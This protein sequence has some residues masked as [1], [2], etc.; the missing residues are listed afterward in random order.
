[1]HSLPPMTSSSIFALTRILSRTGFSKSTPY[2]TEQGQLILLLDRFLYG[3]KQSP[4]KSQ[5]HLSRTLVTTGYTQSINHECLLFKNKGSKFSFV[6]THSDDLLH[7][8]NCQIM[9][10]E[11]KTQLIK[12]YADIQ[13]HD[14]A[15]S[16]I[17]MTI[18]RSDD[19]SIY[20]YLSWDKTNVSSTISCQTT[21]P[22]QHRQPR[23]ISSTMFLMTNHM[24]GL[25]IYQ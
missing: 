8:V 13:Y 1:M 25:N 14:K 7:C 16:Y 4:L 3:L 12:T 22:L 17:G 23:L 10:N 18:N 6:P 9:A 5:L 20:I 24:T 21:F 2:V 15:S 19:L 11:F